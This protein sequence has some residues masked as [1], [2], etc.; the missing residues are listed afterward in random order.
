V[1]IASE[2]HQLR[3]IIDGAL[4]ADLSARPGGAVEDQ[5]FLLGLD[6]K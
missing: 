2:I 1:E 4:F 6:W 5:I 3:G